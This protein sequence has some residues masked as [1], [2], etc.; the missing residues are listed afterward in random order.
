[1]PADKQGDEHL[2]EN[3]LL[4]D[5]YAPDLAHNLLLHLL[6]PRYAASEFGGFNG[7]DRR[8]RQ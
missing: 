3:F 1:V 4:P 5:N 2:V 8:C 7:C 6:E